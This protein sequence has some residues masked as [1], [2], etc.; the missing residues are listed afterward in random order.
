[1]L[2]DTGGLT[3]YDIA[4]KKIMPYLEYHGIK[5]IDTIVITHDD[6]DHCGALDS[7][8]S[9][10]KNADF[11]LKSS[12]FSIFNSKSWSNI[13]MARHWRIYST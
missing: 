12:V 7:L 13:Q 6:F 4:S 1:M 11:H 10:I 8:N 5:K 2:I 3:Y 9:Q